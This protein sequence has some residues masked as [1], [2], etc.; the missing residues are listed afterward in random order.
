MKVTAMKKPKKSAIDEFIALPDWKKDEIANEL[1]LET[2]D[3]M[4]AKSRPLNA[5]ERAI[6]KKFQSK[7]ARRNGIAKISIRLD[8]SLLK[9]A[10]VYAKRHHM[11]RSQ[12]F[13]QSLQRMFRSSKS[14]SA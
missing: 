2:T 12:L 9:Q 10:D 6:W 11:N 4:L 1:A 5:Q 3:E 13:S 7:A 8:Q 14:K